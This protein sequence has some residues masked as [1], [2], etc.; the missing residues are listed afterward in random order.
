MPDENFGS[1]NLPLVSIG[2]PVYNGK[3][4]IRRAL[5]SLLAQT[6]SNFEL[7]VSD[8]ASDDGTWE[9]LQGYAEKEKR[10]KLYRQEHKIGAFGNF[11]FVLSK[12]EGK[13]FMWAAVDDCW[14][15]EFI[16]ALFEELKTHH[17]AGVA[18]CA[19]ERRYEDGI[20]MDV[21]RFDGKKNPHKR[22][23]YGMMKGITS[24]IKY[25]LYIYGL[26][27][28]ELLRKAIRNYPEVPGG[29]RLFVCQL[30]LATRFRYVD[31]ILHIRTNHRVP[32]HVRLPDE[33]FNRMVK[34]ERWLE[35][36]ILV[37][38][39]RMLAK[40]DVI[41]A[42]RKIYIPLALFRYGMLLTKSR[43]IVCIKRHVSDKTYNQ[44]KTI[45]RTFQAR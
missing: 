8:N 31:S 34:E 32:S 2:M 1:E 29:D 36:T 37:S 24:S 9:L 4:F 39:F 27:R 30:A 25:N 22:T 10:I 26:Y 3:H 12:A 6:Y 45:K 44:L 7:I 17:E 38:L 42:K 20:L 23:Y 19:V 28:M 43:I 18:M 11:A 33:R 16:S 35:L 21:V 13:C 41:P 14:L 5:D 15:P 40:S